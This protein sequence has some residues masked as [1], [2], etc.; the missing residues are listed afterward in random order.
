M[1]F[2]GHSLWV[3]NVIGSGS[4]VKIDPSISAATASYPVGPLPQAVLF[5][6]SNIWVASAVNQTLTKLRANDGSLVGSFPS[7]ADPVALAFDGISTWVANRS[8]KTVS[9]R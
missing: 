7:G 2:D 5:D 9:R 4:V 6:G 1:A 3:G 8:T